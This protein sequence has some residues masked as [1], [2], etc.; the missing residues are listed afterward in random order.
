MVTPRHLI[1]RGSSVL[2]GAFQQKEQDEI[3]CYGM[4][5]FDPV[6]LPTPLAS[7]Q[8]MDALAVARSARFEHGEKPRVLS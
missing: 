3:I 7:K 5:D 1:G 2:W 8:V 6:V 4:E